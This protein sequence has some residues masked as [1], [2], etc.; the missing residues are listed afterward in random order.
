MICN[1]STDISTKQ[2]VWV[3]RNLDTGRYIQCVPAHK[4]QVAMRQLST[5]VS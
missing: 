1:I 2:L 4:V 5:P 3:V